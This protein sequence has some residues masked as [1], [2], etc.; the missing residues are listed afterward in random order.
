[1]AG[2]S[3]LVNLMTGSF[4]APAVIIHEYEIPTI[5]SRSAAGKYI[6]PISNGWNFYYVSFFRSHLFV[7]LFVWRLR[8][9]FTA[10]CRMVVIPLSRIRIT[11]GGGKVF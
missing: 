2:K 8:E 9:D 4:V 11:Y 5:F 3:T 6:I 1:M 10:T 7:W